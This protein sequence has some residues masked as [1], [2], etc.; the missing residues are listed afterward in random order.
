M[1]EHNKLVPKMIMIETKWEKQL[2]II[3]L[4]NNSYAINKNPT[5]YSLN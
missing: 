2:P 5:D 1:E 3:P 4:G